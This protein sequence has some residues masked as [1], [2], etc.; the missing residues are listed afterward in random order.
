[1]HNFIFFNL[2]LYVLLFDAYLA[3]TI[4]YLF[5]IVVLYLDLDDST[6]PGKCQDNF[7][8]QVHRPFVGSK[9]CPI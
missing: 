2:Y 7:Y 9:P 3:S 4:Q 5:L 6:V 8:H 1:M